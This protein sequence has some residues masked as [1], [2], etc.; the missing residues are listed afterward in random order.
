MKFTFKSKDEPTQNL[1]LAWK[2]DNSVESFEALCKRHG[3]NN[4]HA[5]AAMT[6][7]APRHVLRKLFGARSK[8]AHSTLVKRYLRALVE[9]KLIPGW[10]QTK[11]CTGPPTLMKTCEDNWKALVA[12]V[13]VDVVLVIDLYEDQNLLEQV[14]D[15]LS[16]NR[17]D[18]KKTVTAATEEAKDFTEKVTMGQ[19]TVLAGEV[20]KNTEKVIVR[21][22]Q[23]AAAVAG[24]VQ[25]L[26]Q[27]VDVL[28][29]LPAAVMALSLQLK[30][31][32]DLEEARQRAE[33]E[34]ARNSPL[35]ELEAEKSEKLALEYQDRGAEPVLTS[36]HGSSYERLVEPPSA[37]SD[38]LGVTPRTESMDVRRALRFSS[39]FGNEQPSPASPESPQEDVA[40]DA[41]DDKAVA[42][43]PAPVLLER[44]MPT[45]A[46][47]AAAALDDD[48][49]VTEVPPREV[50]AP[51]AL[52]EAIVAEAPQG[53]APAVS[54][55]DWN[56]LIECAQ[57]RIRMQEWAAGFPRGDWE[58]PRDP[59]NRD[60]I[61]MNTP[62]YFPM[63]ARKKGIDLADL[64]HE[65]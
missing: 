40:A 35:P 5:A 46:K 26:E 62:H 10:K 22:D 27:K 21:S 13:P 33:L 11:N 43:A 16:E 8:Y 60:K 14:Q 28:A 49:T 44:G 48:K 19:T 55:F 2:G 29:P 42:E 45:G 7:I 6:S 52:D 56:E 54:G 25:A 24:R 30:R 17:E 59:K 36:P 3:K 63:I 32:N 47:A 23:N 65:L 38:M 37:G 31:Q 58:K 15:T 61:E 51:E 41:L 4:F 57:G 34:A 18:I 50:L 1:T 9:D 12:Y 64:R 20:R 53:A 39:I